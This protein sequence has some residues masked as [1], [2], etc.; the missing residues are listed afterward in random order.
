M[1]DGVVQTGEGRT[2]RD[3]LWSCERGRVRRREE[4]GVGGVS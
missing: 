4:G 3:V 2:R 1:D